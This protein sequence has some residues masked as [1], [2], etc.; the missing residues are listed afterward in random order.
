[1]KKSETAES[2]KLSA[3]IEDPELK[4][5][6]E[7]METD[8]SYKEDEIAALKMINTD[9]ESEEIKSTSLSDKEREFTAT[10]KVKDKNDPKK[11]V[12]K[13]AKFRLADV[14]KIHISGKAYTQEAFMADKE[15]QATAAAMNHLLI[16][17][18]DK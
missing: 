18:Q 12:D 10:W 6:V 5:A 7:K 2:V 11:L 9:E 15:A 13:S 3:S 8:L 17:K 4:A 14:P 16:T 1:M